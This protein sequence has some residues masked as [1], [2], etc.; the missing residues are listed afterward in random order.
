MLLFYLILY[1]YLSFKQHEP[2]KSKSAVIDLDTDEESAYN[3]EERNSIGKQINVTFQNLGD[4][5]GTTTLNHEINQ[6]TQSMSNSQNEREHSQSHPASK[7]ENTKNR[8]AKNDTNLDRI[9]EYDEIQAAD[10][11]ELRTTVENTFTENTSN[12]IKKPHP[13]PF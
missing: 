12:K 13:F 7:P 10:D 5:G 3:S 8:K 1:F 4:A 11:S 2:H 9:L 6:E